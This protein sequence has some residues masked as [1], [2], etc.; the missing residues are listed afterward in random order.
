MLVPPWGTRAC[1]AGSPR[2]KKT[3]SASAKIKL[4]VVRKASC[5]VVIGRS[6]SPLNPELRPSPLS[7][8]MIFRKEI[9]TEAYSY[10]TVIDNGRANSS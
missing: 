4:A 2:Q 9:N 6:T 5:G 8:L 1:T 10:S 7:S 3:P